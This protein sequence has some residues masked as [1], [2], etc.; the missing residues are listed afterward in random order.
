MLNQSSRIDVLA[1][2]VVITTSSGAASSSMDTSNVNGNILLC[3]AARA[4]GTN[5]ATVTVQHSFDNSTWATVPAAAI[6]NPI[7]GDET[8]FTGW[9]TAIYEQTLAVD[10][11]RVRKYLRVNITGTTLT[12]NYSII[13]SYAL[14]NVDGTE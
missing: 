9:S 6:T 7:T 11:T 4:G 10:S 2:N 12:Q 1:N 3:V 5:A 8:A 13:A 14:A